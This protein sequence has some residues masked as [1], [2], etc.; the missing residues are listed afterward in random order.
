MSVSHRWFA[1][2]LV[3]LVASLAVGQPQ[4]T[5]KPQNAALAEFQQAVYEFGVGLLIADDRA[6]RGDVTQMWQ[7]LTKLRERTCPNP[8]KQHV[9]EAVQVSTVN[10]KLLA[11]LDVIGNDLNAL[12]K[13]IDVSRATTHLQQA[14]EAAQKQQAADYRREVQCVMDAVV[15]EN[16]GASLETVVPILREAANL[17]TGSTS[18][19]QRERALD[20]LRK[21]PN[22]ERGKNRAFREALTQADGLIA[23]AA[24]LYVE[25]YFLQGKQQLVRAGSPLMFAQRTAP[26]PA[27][28]QKVSIVGQELQTADRVLTQGFTLDAE[29]GLGR[30][31]GARVELGELVEAAGKTLV[32]GQPVSQ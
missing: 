19:T 31:R 15:G 21:L 16:V 18:A 10:D 6:L 26:T 28:A 3:I 12:G 9:R 1:G 11:K 7:H 29:L 4:S 22:F 20:V 2:L 24:D 13:Q 27:I 30:L 25:G 14:C 8:L 23:S 5:T 17:L 32:E